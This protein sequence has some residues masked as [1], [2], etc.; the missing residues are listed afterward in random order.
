[1]KLLSLQLESPAELLAADEVLLDAA[2]A[3]NGPETLWFWEPR[4]TF[5]VT[6]YGNQVTTEVAVAN[7]A[8]RGIP[9]F[10]RCS[11]GG[12]VVQLPGGLNYSLVLRITPDGPLRNITAANQ[13]IMEKNRNAIASLWPD[14]ASPD[15]ALSV[16]GHTD[17]CRGD[18]KFAG[19]S[20]RRRKNYLLFHGTLLLDCDL[21]RI[22][23]LLPMPSLQ[24]DYRARRSHADFLTN[25]ALPAE[26]VKAALARE[27]NAVEDSRPPPLAQIS[28]LARDKYSLREWNFKF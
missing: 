15:S 22:S 28:R 10:R 2:E 13:F 27:W 20:Q 5:V 25:L 7:C 24:P 14:P 21:Q 8:A 19:N 11:G 26:N 6:G 23:E 4:H 1:M 9:I 3:E 16:R 17:L 18:L 12:T